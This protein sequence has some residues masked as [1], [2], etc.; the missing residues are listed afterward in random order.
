MKK[1][2]FIISAFILIIPFTVNAEECPR[3]E[4]LPEIITPGSETATCHIYLLPSTETNTEIIYNGNLFRGSYTDLRSDFAMSGN[5]IYYQGETLENPQCVKAV[6][7]TL[8]ASNPDGYDTTDTISVGE[9]SA[10]ITVKYQASTNN[11]LASLTIGNYAVELNESTNSY[12]YTTSDANVTIAATT[13]DS[14]ATITGDIGEKSLKFGKNTYY[15]TVKAE[16]GAINTYKI[17]ITRSDQRSSIN[18]LSSLKISAGKLSP[19]FSSSVTKY[20][21]TVDY[22]VDVITISATLSDSKASFLSDPKYRPGTRILVVGETPLYIK[23]QA[24]D[25]TKKTYEIIVTRS[26]KKSNSTTP[27]TPTPTTG[28]TYLKNLEIPGITIVFDKNVLE[29]NASVLHEVTKLDVKAEAENAS[30]RVEISGND[31]LQIGNNVITI[32]VTNNGERIYKVNVERKSEGEVLSDNNYLYSLQINGHNIEF[33]KNS[34]EYTIKIKDEKELDIIAE[35]E[36][37]NATVVIKGNEDL[38]NNS[39]IVISVISEDGS[40]RDYTINVKKALNVKLIIIIAASVLGVALIV[41]LIVFRKKLFKPS[42]PQTISASS[43]SS[44]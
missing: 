33:N 12:S 38:K 4:C 26:Q 40:I 41:L 11:K 27:S 39:K 8:I 7:L 28:N 32:K 36:D 30:A 2:L 13:E 34:Q 21:A 16:S 20:K 6:D 35:S 31:N 44:R 10:Q 15:I 29:Y 14:K 22:S 19:S 43:L 25:G 37:E 3:I 17:V 24:E 9:A 42:T 5:L 18:T 23:V 1:I